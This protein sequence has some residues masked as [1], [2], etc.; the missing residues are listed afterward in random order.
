MRLQRS[1]QKKNAGVERKEKF[2]LQRVPEEA[3]AALLQVVPSMY[4]I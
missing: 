1:E 3:R 2:V 4:C